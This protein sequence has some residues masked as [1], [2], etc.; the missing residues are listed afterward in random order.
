MKRLFISLLAATGLIQVATAGE[1]DFSAEPYSIG[2]G[3][4]GVGGWE[5]RLAGDESKTLARVVKVRWD[6]DKPALILKGASLK[7]AEVKVPDSQAN[8]TFSCE[9]AFNFTSRT[10]ADRPFRFSI[11]GAPFNEIFF[12]RSEKGGFGFNGEGTGRGGGTVIL[13]REEIKPNSFYRLSAMVDYPNGSYTVELTGTKKDGSAFH[14][15]SEEL[16][17]EPTPTSKLNMGQVSYFICSPLIT[18]YL[19]DLK[20]E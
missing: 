7:N 20:V 10:A 17:F 2:K 16:S 6:G 9:L 14:F 1:A 5:A 12:D 13:P 15:R 4:I 19:R 11:G 18:V 8:L 3:V